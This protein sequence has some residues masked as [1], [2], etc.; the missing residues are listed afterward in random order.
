MLR[1]GTPPLFRGDNMKKYDELENLDE[2]F[3]VNEEAEQVVDPV[4]VIDSLAGMDESFDNYMK[5]E[6]N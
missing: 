5:E 3:D 4:D 1:G 2:T 6:G